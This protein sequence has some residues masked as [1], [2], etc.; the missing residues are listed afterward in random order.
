M[1]I[2]PPTDTI[3]QQSLWLNALAIGAK[4]SGRWETVLEKG[5]AAFESKFWNEHAGYLAD[6]ID[7]DHQ[8]GVLDLTFRPNQIFAVGGLPLML[9]SKE[10]ARRVVDAVE[11]LLLTPVGLRSLAPGEAGF[12]AR[13][14]SDSRARDSVYHHDTV[15]PWLIGPF[16]EAWMRVHGANAAAREKAHT[17]FLP[18]LYEHLNHAG[19]GHI[20]EFC[21]A[22]PSHMPRG[23]PFQA[24][25]LG[26]LLRLECSVLV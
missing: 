26:E 18:P 24:W 7:C 23:C 19:L 20:S 12:A 22:E 13:Y 15:W 10:K 5:R 14:E 2:N 17:R 9:L 1:H 4:F 3:A 8:P 11:M 6:V 21:D 25:S 16:A